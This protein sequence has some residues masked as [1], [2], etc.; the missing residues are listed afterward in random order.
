MGTPERRRHARLPKD[1]RITGQEITYPLGQAP[2]LD[3]QMLDVSE[4]GARFDSPQPFAPGTLVQ[5]ALVLAGWHRHK[6]GFL[7]YDDTSV[8]KPLTALARVVRC[9]PAEG[10]VHELG[11]E[12][13]DIWDDHWRAMR[14]YLERELS[15]V[16]AQDD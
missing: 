4:A 14:I 7:K 1:A 6:T 12:F 3:L 5:V 10:G 15:R 13:V 8:S 11:V 16:E 9:L 2:E